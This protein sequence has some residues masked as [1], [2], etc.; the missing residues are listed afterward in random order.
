[1]NVRRAAALLPTLATA[2]V[3]AAAAAV[4]YGLKAHFSTANGDALR[5]VLAPTCWLAGHLGAI[6]FVDEAGA[7]FISHAER[8]VVGPA[9]SGLNFLIVCF[10]ALFFLLAHR[11][12]GARRRA[13]WLVGCLGLAYLATILTNATRVVLAA[14]LYHLPLDGDLLTPSRLHRLLGTALYC[15]SLVGLH[16][17][18][19]RWTSGRSR[20]PAETTWLAPLGA[21]A[22][23]TLVVPLLRRPSL[24]G[25]ARF[26]EH[27]T[28]VVGTIVALGALTVATRS[29][30]RLL[31]R[32]RTRGI[33]SSRNRYAIS[34][35]LPE[36]PV[37]KLVAG[38]SMS[39]EI[40]A[41]SRLCGTPVLPDD[42]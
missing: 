6:A 40:E 11:L 30:Y 28:F 1:V 39:V 22:G 25:D 32:L 26:V 29:T 20:N 23:I 35:R 13:A 37:P 3:Y 19:D 2:S 4:V 34:V 24:C 16:R 21:Y 12:D 33:A 36:Y 42:Q 38:M 8:L 41:S 27:A 7:G 10:A 15:V 5:W 18:A 9:C 14:R 17:A 31:S